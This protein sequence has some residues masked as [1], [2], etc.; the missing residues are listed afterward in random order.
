MMI[1]EIPVLQNKAYQK[2]ENFLLWIYGSKYLSGKSNKTIGSDQSVCLAIKP[3]MEL[4][5]L[6]ERS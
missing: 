1:D 4:M 5:M 2:Y 3:N 6:F